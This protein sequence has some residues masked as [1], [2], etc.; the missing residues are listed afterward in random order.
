M[1][2]PYFLVA[3]NYRKFNI[4]R[5]LGNIVYFIFDTKKFVTY[6][7]FSISNPQLC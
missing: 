5:L 4:M 3:I 7:Q 2:L 1:G 6:T